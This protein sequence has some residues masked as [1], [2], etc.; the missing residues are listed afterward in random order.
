MGSEK[1]NS[2]VEKNQQKIFTEKSRV[3]VPLEEKLYI[4]NGMHMR[5]Y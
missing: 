3:K 1:E 2:R 4:K 5:V